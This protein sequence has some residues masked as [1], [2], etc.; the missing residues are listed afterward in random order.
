MLVC[1]LATAIPSWNTEV[2]QLGPRIG[3]VWVTVQGLNVDAVATFNVKT[4][5]LSLL[6]QIFVI[7]F[8]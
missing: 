2:K 7:N 5:K 3:L 1:I 8:F 4:E 6:E